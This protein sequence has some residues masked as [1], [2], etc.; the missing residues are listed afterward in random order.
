MVSDGI[1]SLAGKTDV[2]SGWDSLFHTHNLS[3]GKQSGYEKGQK[4]AIKTNMNGAG[5][6][7]DDTNPVLLKILL[8]SLVMDAGVTPED[9]IVYDAGR[10]IPDYIQKMCNEGILQGI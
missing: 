5:A 4:I 6:Y 1:A 10:M 7:S 2:K 3:N 8:I 9:I